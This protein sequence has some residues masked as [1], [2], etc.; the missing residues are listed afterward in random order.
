MNNNI[1]NDNTV[2]RGDTQAEAAL[3]FNAT[4]TQIR[5]VS[6]A[7]VAMCQIIDN[8]IIDVVLNNGE[9][10]LMNTTEILEFIWL[11]AAPE[12]VVAYCVVR[13]GSQPE[14]LREEVLMWSMNLTPEDMLNYIK[15]I[16][17]DKQNI[18]NSKSKVIPE[19]GKKQ[20]KNSRSQECS[21]G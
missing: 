4:A 17:K 1:F 13:Y 16:T 8:K 5:P 3:P 20:R 11:H 10:N 15:D 2:S 7:S 18:N 14:L 9:L 19:K 6:M 12:D 21:N